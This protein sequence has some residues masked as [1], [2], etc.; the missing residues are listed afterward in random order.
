MIYIQS[1]NDI[2]SA[3][4]YEWSIILTVSGYDLYW[5]LPLALNV[6]ISSDMPVVP[7]GI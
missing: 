6:P 1:I 2:K 3:I 5:Q 4:F 7:L